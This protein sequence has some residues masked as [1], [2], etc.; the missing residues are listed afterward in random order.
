M[1]QTPFADQ[2]RNE[3]DIAT[4]AVGNITTADQVN[5]IIAAGR[6]DLCA[7]ARP[8]L[9]D[10]HFTLSAAAHYGYQPQVWPNQYL[11]ARDQAQRLAERERARD[12]DLLEAAAPPPPAYRDVSG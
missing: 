6:A 12:R 8:H 10:P 5:T 11:A 1:F 3:A 7:L 9:T 4:I 2:V